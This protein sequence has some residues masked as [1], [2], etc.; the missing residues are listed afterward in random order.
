M[1]LGKTTARVTRDDELILRRRMIGLEQ[2]LSLDLTRC[3]GCGD[4]EA[5]CPAAA[6]SITEAVVE[7]G[8]VVKRAVA[9]IDPGACTYCGECVVI[10]PTK[11]I[12]W[13]E[14]EDAIPTVIRAGILPPLDE[15]IRIEVESCRTDCGLACVTSC[16]VDAIRVT[17]QDDGSGSPRVAEVSVDTRRCLYCGRCAPA[18]PYGAVRVTRSR[19]GLARLDR[20][21]C[22]A[23]C[24]ACAEVCP[25]RALEEKDGQVIL[26]EDA[27]IYCRACARVCPVPGALEVRREMIRVSFPSSRMWAELLE[28]LA[29]PAAMLRYVQEAA[30]GKRARACRTRID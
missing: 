22:P 20:E 15:H 2:S 7:H 4:C 5:I 6:V 17:L 8:G 9:D 18:C 26:D 28:K 11:S 24:R 14:N 19:S 29:S 10:C 16:P 23:S 25:T 21:K 12:S 13:R 27:C 3:C 1:R 30:A